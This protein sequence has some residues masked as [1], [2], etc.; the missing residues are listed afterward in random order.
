MDFDRIVVTLIFLAGLTGIGTGVW[1]FVTDEY[2]VGREDICM[3]YSP[4]TGTCAKYETRYSCEVVNGP[5]LTYCDVAS[6]CAEFC[7][8][9]RQK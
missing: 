5:T 9:Q 8:A 3:E 4:N 7:N 6:D 1:A 2:E